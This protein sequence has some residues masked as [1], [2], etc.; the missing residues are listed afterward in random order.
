MTAP[1]P[2]PSAGVHAPPSMQPSQPGPMASM[3]RS[4]DAPPTVLPQTGMHG[5]N[6]TVLIL[7]A[8]AMFVVGAFTILASKLRR[9][10]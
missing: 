5:G 9:G 7:A 3:T 10:R 6:V 8:V 2:E 4:T 1:T